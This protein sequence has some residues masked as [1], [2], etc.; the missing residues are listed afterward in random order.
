[1]AQAE[2]QYQQRLRDQQE[3]EQQRKAENYL[4]SEKGIDYRRLRDLLKAQNFKDADQETYMRMLEAVGRKNGDYFRPDDLL[5]F[6]CTDF[7]TI[8]RLWVKYSDGKFGFSVQKEI[9]VQCGAKLDGN[10]PGDKIF[11]EF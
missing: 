7:N 8:D 11:K 10:Y 1:M 3:A 6:P 2:A 4:P 5:N 9:Y